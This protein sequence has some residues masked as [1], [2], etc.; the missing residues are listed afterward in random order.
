VISSSVPKSGPNRRAAAL[1]LFTLAGVAYGCGG[2]VPTGASPGAPPGKPLEELVSP[3]KL[4]KWE[5]T[6]AAKHKVELSRKER[7]QLRHE[8]E[9]KAN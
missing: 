9:K 1:V 5:G 6:G 3:D 4:Y 2:S 8:A 7:M